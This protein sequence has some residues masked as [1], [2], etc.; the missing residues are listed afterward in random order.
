M[1]V[2][3]IGD[4]LGLPR[5]DV[6]YEDTWFYNLKKEFPHIEF[7][8]Y[9]ERRLHIYKALSNFDNYYVFYPSDVVVIQ[10]GICDCSPRYVLEESLVVK[11]LIIF[12]SI[13]H[14][15][16]LFWKIVKLRGRRQNCVDTPIDVF[17][18]KFDSLITKFI[19]NGVKQIILVKIG[20]VSESVVNKNKYINN[21]VEKYNRVIDR[22]REKYPTIIGVIDPLDQV[23][24]SLF[25]DGYHCNKKGMELVYVSLRAELDNNQ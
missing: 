11:L 3:C 23:D 20:H 24:D 12:F 5:E 10:V 21:N 7:V 2:L 22:L 25:V 6:S 14:L 18:A 19:G 15:K 1:R 4:S 9:F 17:Y 16:H 13:I 8:D